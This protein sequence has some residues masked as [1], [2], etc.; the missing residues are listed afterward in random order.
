MISNRLR[1]YLDNRH[2]D[3]SI[4]IHRPAYTAKE[5][6]QFD[7]TP[8]RQMAKTVVFVADGDYGM[9]LLPANMHVDPQSLGQALGA[10]DLRLASESEL[11]KLFPDVE[12]GA[13]PPFANLY[14]I[15]VYIDEHL[16]SHHEVSFNAGSHAEAIHMK[17]HDLIKLSDGLVTR[18]ARRN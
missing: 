16:A 1:D 9:A 15:P 4:S 11:L 14:G 2:V 7:H 5:T 3:Y 12:V 13:A 6:A 10:S 18:F 8:A 17:V